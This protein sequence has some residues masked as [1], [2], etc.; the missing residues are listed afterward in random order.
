M[1]Q[2]D[3]AR[4]ATDA[5]D[6]CVRMDSR[7]AGAGTPG[8]VLTPPCHALQV[9]KQG[10]LTTYGTHTVNL[11]VIEKHETVAEE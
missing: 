2:P 1:H 10:V 8:R 3:S 11:T 4:I 6:R 9:R 7:L 5:R